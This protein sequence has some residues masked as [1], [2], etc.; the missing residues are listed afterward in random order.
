MRKESHGYNAAMINF[1]PA[2]TKVGPG[3]WS[4]YL[5]Y[6]LR[7]SGASRAKLT[8]VCVPANSVRLAGSPQNDNTN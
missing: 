7:F 8:A 3:A 1:T 6:V 2:S 4:V 5:T